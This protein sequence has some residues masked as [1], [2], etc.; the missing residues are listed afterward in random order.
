MDEEM[1]IVIEF[2]GVQ[3][4]ITQTDFIEMPLNGETSVKDALEYVKC[5]FPTLT[6]EEENVLATVNQQAVSPDEL[7]KPRDRVCFLP[8][9]GGG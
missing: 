9:I 8:G 4:V 6:L 7:L 1:T 5:Q 2:F 3:K